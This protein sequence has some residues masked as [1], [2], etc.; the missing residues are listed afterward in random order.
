MSNNGKNVPL[1]VFS[2]I[3]FGYGPNN[4]ERKDRQRLVTVNANILP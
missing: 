1:E 2:K 3:E 4:I